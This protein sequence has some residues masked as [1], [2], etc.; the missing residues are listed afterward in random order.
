MTDIQHLWQDFGLDYLEDGIN[1]LFPEKHFSLMAVLEHLICGDFKAAGEDLWNGFLQGTVGNVQGMKQ[2]FVS[3]LVIGIASAFAVDLINLFEAKQISDLGFYFI[4]LCLALIL[5]CSFRQV[6]SLTD[7]SLDQMIRFHE[8]LFPSYLLTVGM[9]T[10]TATM[11]VS[12]Q[13]VLLIIYGIEI[14]FRGVV[15]PMI[16][17]YM[18]LAVLNGVWADDHLML[19]IRLIG[20]GIGWI[21]NISLWTVTGVGFFQSVLT[22]VIDSAQNS[23]WRKVIASLPGI[24]DAAQGVMEVLLG[25]AHLI[26]NSVGIVLLVLLLGMCLGPLLQIGGMCLVMKTAAACMGPIGDK[27]V[28]KCTDLVGESLFL[29]LRTVATAM[30]LFGIS[31][32]V[33]IVT[34]VRV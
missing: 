20:R 15:F 8:V 2:V 3:L 1:S 28:A 33:V 10:G 19:F 23:V 25:S 29:L 21:L 11:T 34:S 30:L 27:R 4:Y 18:I 5:T 17:C 26:K 31:I 22:P 16:K 6:S 12:H 7:N 9:A 13:M 24:G 14:L 32:G